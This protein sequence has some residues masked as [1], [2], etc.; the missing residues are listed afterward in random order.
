M[1][2]E[3]RPK[4]P[5]PLGGALPVRA[6]KAA[7]RVKPSVATVTRAMPAFVA[8]RTRERRDVQREKE[9]SRFPVPVAT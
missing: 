6:D 5:V 3:Q 1:I 4:S 9:K 8:L 2:E 7:V